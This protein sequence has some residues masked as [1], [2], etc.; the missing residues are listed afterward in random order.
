MER[1]QNG[2]IYK[3]CC[4][5]PEIKDIYVGSTCNFKRRKHQH[6]SNI[7]CMNNKEY[8]TYKYEFIRDHGGWENWDMVQIESFPCGTK[9]EL[10]TRERF[11]LESLG[12]T[13]NKSIP[14]RNK[15]EYKEYIKEYRKAN[16]DKLKK[17]D[18]VYR[19]AN[20]DKLKEYYKAN[21]EQIFNK[22]K[23][24]VTCDCGSIV[25]KHGLSRHK[26]TAKHQAYIDSL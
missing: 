1:Y 13:L 19:E 26:K 8:K 17:K 18:K 4:L 15:E 22:R 11:W 2:L 12:T 16:Q 23:E 3:I 6:K 9:R 10:G 5:D 21:K 24:K 25:V 7:I 14:T 20:Q